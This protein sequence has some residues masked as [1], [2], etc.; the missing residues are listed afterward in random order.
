MVVDKVDVVVEDEVDVVVEVAVV[1]ETPDNRPRPLV[2]AALVGSEAVA[3]V[4]AEPDRV[5][6]RASKLLLVS[7]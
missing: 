4:H 5:S 3:G 7:R 1:H 6:T 2:E